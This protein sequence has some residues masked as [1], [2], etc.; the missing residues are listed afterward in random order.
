MVN[1][2]G[3]SFRACPPP[4]RR[5]VGSPPKREALGSVR[6]PEERVPI[7]EGESPS[8]KRCAR[9]QENGSKTP[10]LGG[11]TMLKSIF[12][13]KKCFFLLLV[14][15]FFI[16]YSKMSP[17]CH[18]FLEQESLP[19]TI[20]CREAL[21]MFCPKNMCKTW[22]TLN[23]LTQIDI[24]YRVLSQV[25]NLFQLTFFYILFSR[26]KKSVSIYIFW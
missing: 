5:C 25:R 26:A 9:V 4:P 10:L 3:A 16:F 20:F 12:K 8:Q 24:F 6:A 21:K 1:Y 18:Y 19:I 11:G 2:L 15:L 23:R 22:N 7:K 14:S 13:N 17:R